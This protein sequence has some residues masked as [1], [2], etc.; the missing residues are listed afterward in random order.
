MKLSQLQKYILLNSV[1]LK[2]KLKRSQLLKFYEKQKSPPK[3]ADQQGIVTKSLERLI[4]KGLMI[5]YGRRT[6][7]KWFIEE[8]R[9]TGQGQ[10]EARKLFGQQQVLPLH[11][12]KLKINKKLYGHPQ[13]VTFSSG[14]KQN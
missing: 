1:G 8:V 5:G 4:E 7:E 10:R 11:L 3:K 14:Q 12:K 6:P 2:G 9:L 13:K